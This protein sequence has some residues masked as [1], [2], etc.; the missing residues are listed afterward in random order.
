MSI[1]IQGLKSKEKPTAPMSGEGP[2]PEG[3]CVLGL[4]PL[5]Q[6]GRLLSLPAQSQSDG[7]RTRR[8]AVSPLFSLLPLLVPINPAPSSF[9]QPKCKCS[10]KSIWQWGNRTG[11]GSW[12]R[13]LLRDPEELSV[14][15]SSQTPFPLGFTST[16]HTC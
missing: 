8:Q 16:F 4:G 7:N 12:Q 2:P 5:P 13:S 11:R 9:N 14:G 6:P 1:K 15:F 3:P 10:S